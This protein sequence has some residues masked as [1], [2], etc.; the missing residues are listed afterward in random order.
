MKNN[1]K[2]PLKERP[3][4]VAGQSLDDLIQ[5]HASEDTTTLFFLPAILIIVTLTV[6]LTRNSSPRYLPLMMLIITIITT[7]YCTYKLIILWKRIK[8]LKLG[9]NGERIVAE[10][11]DNLRS[12]GFVVFHDIVAENFNVDHV[13]LTPH[14]IFTVETKT[15]SKSP[16]DKITFKNEDII[17][18]NTNLGNKVILQAESQSKWLKS[19]LKDSTGRDYHI[20]PVIVFPGWF[21]QPMPENLKKRIWILNPQALP[22]FINNEPK[23]INES[24]M[25]LAAFHI[26]RYI[27][28]HS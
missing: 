12:K 4:H 2:S 8:S 10:I 26:S 25:H 21:V 27:R 17:A 6:W 22:S 9:R 16:K 20:M 13:I 11:F 1:K 19:I 15:L 18:G 5:K 24:D 3:L 14:G 7:V 28:T 23:T